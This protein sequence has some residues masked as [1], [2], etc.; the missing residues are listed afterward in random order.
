MAFF[1]RVQKKINNLWYP[2]SVTVG[3]PVSSRE[4]ADQLSVLS[5]LTRGDTYAVIENLG[6]VLGNYMSQG[7]SVKIDG[8]GT[9]Y[10]TANANKQGVKKAEEVKATLIKGV[11][12]RFIPEVE[13]SSGR[14]VTTRSMVGN[15]VFWEEW[16]K[17]TVESDKG[18]GSSTGGN[19]SGGGKDNDPLG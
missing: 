11:R 3:K 19:T 13:R 12:V 14:Q 16:G 6:Q 1:K 2:Q 5:T 15:S 18:N 4:V 9:F 17:K 7:R 8:L 10:Y